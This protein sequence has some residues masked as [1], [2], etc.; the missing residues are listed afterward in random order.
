MFDR[1]GN[2]VDLVK[3]I[4]AEEEFFRPLGPAEL[5]EVD[6]C[7]GTSKKRFRKYYNK[8]DNNELWVPDDREPHLRKDKVTAKLEKEMRA[9]EYR[10]KKCPARWTTQIRALRAMWRA[11]KEAVAFLQQFAWMYQDEL[12][13]WRKERLG[14]A[15]RCLQD[16]ESV[17]RLDY[18]VGQLCKADRL[19]RPA[20]FATKSG[21]R[22][23]YRACKEL[24]APERKEAWRLWHGRKAGGLLQAFFRKVC[25]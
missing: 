9:L 8:A 5:C 19:G 3:N 17:S 21:G 22:N 14:N 18:L 16:T 13:S 2:S 1:N 15:R 11:R 23:F 20:C 24:Q 12:Q 10:G 25:K 7:P 6:I 4:N